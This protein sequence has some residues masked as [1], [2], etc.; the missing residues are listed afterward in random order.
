M[1]AIFKRQSLYV[2]I[3]LIIG[4]LAHDNHLESIQMFSM[5]TTAYPTVRQHYMVTS[6]TM[7]TMFSNHSL[8]CTQLLFLTRTRTHTHM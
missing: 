7:A 5:R 4:K 8:P 1:L 6:K 3:A 2:W